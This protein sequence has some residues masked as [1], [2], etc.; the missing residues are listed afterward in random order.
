MNSNLFSYQIL[1]ISFD[2]GSVLFQD[3]LNADALFDEFI[4]GKSE[5]AINI[6]K[7]FIHNTIASI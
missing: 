7:N 4:R 6:H 1:A 5:D 3:K 2:Y